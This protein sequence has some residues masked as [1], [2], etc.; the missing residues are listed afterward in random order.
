MWHGG[1]RT[2]ELA[3]VAGTFGWADL[4]PILQG[5]GYSPAMRDDELQR[6]LATTL[7]VQL[8]GHIAHHVARGDTDGAASNVAA[9]RQALHVL[10]G[11][12]AN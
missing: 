3:H 9:V 8:I 5:Y 7:A 2:G 11:D 6:L 1:S 10:D 12:T 4:E